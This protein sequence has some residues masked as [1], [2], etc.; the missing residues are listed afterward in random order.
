MD[1]LS[2]LF[3]TLILIFLLVILGM[4]FINLIRTVKST[5][6]FVV[7]TS[8]I[9]TQVRAV[10]DPMAFY[11]TPATLQQATPDSTSNSDGEQLCTLFTQ[12]RDTLA[13]NEGAGQTLSDA[14]ISKR[15]ET[16]LASSIPGGALDCPLLKYPSSNSTDL[17]WLAFVQAIPEDFG[18]RVV[19]MAQYADTEMTSVSSQMKDALSGN[20]TVPTLIKEPFAVNVCP[21]NIAKKKRDD[22]EES[23][24]SLPEDL[25]PEQIQEA[26]ATALQNLLDKKN[27]ILKAKFIDPT[28]TIHQNIVNATNAA[29][30]LNKQH[31]AIKSGNVPLT[32]PIAGLS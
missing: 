19:F 4:N 21:A 25:S 20:I 16:T 13:K 9:E 29:A 1:R 22:Q 3:G 11:N 14:E 31:D 28:T 15:V 27:T 10:L 17:E 5:E 30:Y 23:A 24:C 18:A 8:A 7:N 32:A 2:T 12:V 26:I 6:G